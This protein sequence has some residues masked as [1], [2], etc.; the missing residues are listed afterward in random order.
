MKGLNTST[1][2]I[3]IE[4]LYAGK[5]KVSVEF[6]E[7]NNEYDV[8]LTDILDSPDCKVG[9]WGDNRWFRTEKGACR[10]KYANISNLKRGISMSAKSRGLSVKNFKIEMV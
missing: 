4:D 6:N 8:E 5:A 9:S 7:S 10:K 1:S 2:K 3:T